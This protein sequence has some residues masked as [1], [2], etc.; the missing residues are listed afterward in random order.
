MAHI[1]RRLT[2]TQT[3]TTLN[4]AMAALRCSS[5]GLKAA[6]DTATLEVAFRNVAQFQAA[7]PFMSKLDSI[8]SVTVLQEKV[9]PWETHHYGLSQSPPYTSRD[10]DLASPIMHEKWHC[11]L[12]RLELHGVSLPQSQGSNDA[13]GGEHP[14]WH[15]RGRRSRIMRGGSYNR[16]EPGKE[17]DDW[18]PDLPALRALTLR[19]TSVRVLDVSKCS[20][21]RELRLSYCSQLEGFRGLSACQ[22]LRTLHLEANP[23]MEELH[24]LSGCRQ[25]L[26]VTSLHNGLKLLDL[27]GCHTLQSLTLERNHRLVTISLQGCAGLQSMDLRGTSSLP[28]LD[29]SPCTALQKLVCNCN[30]AIASLVIPT[31]SQLTAVQVRYNPGCRGWTCRGSQPCRRWTAR[32]TPP[33][34]RA[35]WRAAQGCRP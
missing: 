22:E 25:L 3:S 7:T 24:S 4:Q 18:A 17:E 23:R 6:A 32:A 21:L 14:S 20:L 33:W 31:S 30:E 19:D 28:S 29:L 2:Q 9:N 16:N 11:L 13:R 12:Q 34:S 15:H 27:A 5:P 8:T 10:I 1:F 35:T 26:T